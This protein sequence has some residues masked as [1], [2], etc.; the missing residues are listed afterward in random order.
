MAVNKKFNNLSRKQVVVPAFSVATVEYND[1]MPNYYR[2]MNM[3]ESKLYCSTAYIPSPKRYDF[4]IPAQRGK[5]Y[6]E[7]SIRNNLYICNPSG[8]DIEVVVVAFEAEFEPATLAMSDMEF[9]VAGQTMETRTVIDSFNAE[10]PQGNNN[11][12]SVGINGALPA[13]TNNIGK[14]TVENQKDYSAALADILTALNTIIGRLTDAEEV[15][16]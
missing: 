15:S 12:G 11:I 9:D 14:V 7:P 5:L 10:L 2:I 16:Y 13:G 8:S 6:T 4:A 1:S 3:G